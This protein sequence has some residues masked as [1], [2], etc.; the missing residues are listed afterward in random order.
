MY[1]TQIFVNK[2]M[3]HEYTVNIFTIF[4][5]VNKYINKWKFL[6]E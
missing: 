4:A 5:L 1:G 3:E 6:K 2:K